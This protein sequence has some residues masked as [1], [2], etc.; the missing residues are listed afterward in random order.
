M[1]WSSF[2]EFLKNFELKAIVK[3]IEALTKLLKVFKGSS[4]ETVV[5]WINTMVIF[6]VLILVVA[7]N[8]LHSEDFIADIT[9]P[10]FLTSLFA[11][12]V[13]II[14]AFWFCCM[15]VLAAA[16]FSTEKHK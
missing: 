5:A 4:I 7:D 9:L 10:E 8:A 14:M 11:C 16:K 6:G 15:M 2:I 1:S 3:L 12:V 13:L